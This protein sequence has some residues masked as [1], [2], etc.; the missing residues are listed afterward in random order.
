MIRAEMLARMPSSEFF[1]WMLLERLEPF[2]DRRGDV[3]VAML[4]SLI[5]NI[6]RASGRSPYT[7]NDFLLKYET[8][9]PK[10]AALT[11]EQLHAKFLKL[12]E[13]LRRAR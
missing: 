5:A 7:M 8:A 4:A 10:S 11:P 3:Q 2:G 12:T 1:E 6:Y 13:K 9:A